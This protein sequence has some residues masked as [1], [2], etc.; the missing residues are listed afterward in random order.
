M[1]DLETVRR[2][3]SR[4]KTAILLLTVLVSLWLAFGAGQNS[5]FAEQ[6]RVFPKQSISTKVFEQALAQGRL[7][8]GSL[9]V[10]QSGA[11]Y[12]DGKFR[13]K[14]GGLAVTGLQEQITPAIIQALDARHITVHGSLG[15]SVTPAVPAR[16]QLDWASLISIFG[17]MSMGFVYLIFSG[18]MLLYAR[19]M[20]ESVATN[21]FSKQAAGEGSRVRFSDV[22]GMTGPKLEISEAVGYLRDPKAIQALGGRAT[23]GVLLYGPPGNGKTLLAKAVAGEAGVPFLEQNASSFM[24]LYVGAGAM[25]VRSLFRQARKLGSCVIFIDEIDA[26]G[27][28]RFGGAGGHD[29]RLQT[30]NALLA[31]MDGFKENTGVLVIAATNALDHLDEALVRPGRFDRKVHVPLPGKEDRQAI[32]SYYI[33]KLPR[34]DVRVEILAER[35]GGFSAAELGNWANEAAMEAARSHDSIVTELHFSL[36]RERIL[37][38]PR[39]FGVTLTSEEKSTTAWH[40]A[41]HAVV[42]LALGGRVDK[43]SILPRGQALGVTYSIQ[44]EER[45]LLTRD[46]LHKELMVL[47]GGRAAE[48]QFVGQVSA[49]AGNDMEK[50]SQL[51]RQAVF[52]MGLG[53][54]GPYVPE[55]EA[56]RAKAEEEARDW[57]LQAYTD[58]ELVLRD[59]LETMRLMQNLLLERDELDMLERSSEFSVKPYKGGCA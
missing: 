12:F 13:G 22:A 44:E 48:S 40:E 30:L 27:T 1:I 18:I 5:G 41:G 3:V 51:A 32:L 58:A 7:G 37:V 26:I 35:S 24:Q 39:N 6:H 42:R 33:Q 53:S 15:F 49:G 45:L 10:A 36:S 2:L 9:W 56:L 23:K 47:M 20:M 38:G 34:S 8:P 59:N 25:A 29:E 17:K 21:R 28:K 16:A 57:V 55:G 43:I 31:E 19:Q 54:F 14:E 11:I 52:R 4:H 50:A 46:S